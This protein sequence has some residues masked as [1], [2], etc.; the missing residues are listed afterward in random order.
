MIEYVP[1]PSVPSSS[2]VP[3]QGSGNDVDGAEGA[4]NRWVRTGCHWKL[5]ICT[6]NARSLSS[7]DRVTE[8]EEEI[9]RIK[10]DIIG[11]SET[12]RTGEGCLTPNT[13]GHTFYY[14]G[15]DTYHRDVGFIVNKSIACNV[16][17]FKSVSDRLAQ[18]TIRINGKYHLNTIQ[19]CLPTSSHEDQEVESI[20]EDIDNLITNSKAHY[21]VIVDHF[22]AK[23]G[24]GDP[25]KPC[26]GPYGLRSRNTRE[27]S[28]IN[29]AESH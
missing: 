28:L 12:R 8:F 26:I 4:E 19:A 6:Y 10:F 20:Y 15:G 2:G 3:I 24:L 23:V 18:L 7:D 29:F 11:I 25:A 9:A 1:R 14:K 22:N 27:D 17:R 5:K 16:T 21:N 13:S